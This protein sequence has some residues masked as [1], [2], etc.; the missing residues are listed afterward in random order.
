MLRSANASLKKTDEIPFR[1]FR[2]E[3]NKYF[4]QKE[5]RGLAGLE[6]AG[7]TAQH[8]MVAA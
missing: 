3:R 5:V 4:R 8:L 2:R 7:R 6:V 1:V